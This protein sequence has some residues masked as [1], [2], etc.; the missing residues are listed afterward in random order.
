M[1]GRSRGPLVL[2][3][4]TFFRCRNPGLS[5]HQARRTSPIQGQFIRTFHDGVGIYLGVLRASSARLSLRLAHSQAGARHMSTSPVTTVAFVN[6]LS[7]NWQNSS[8]SFRTPSSSAIPGNLSFGHLDASS[9]PIRNTP[10]GSLTL[11]LHFRSCSAL[12]SII[13][14]VSSTKGSL[15]NPALITVDKGNYV[16]ISKRTWMTR[17]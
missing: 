16:V 14:T 17:A 15:L 11:A 6:S 8:P 13:S 7:W 1:L 2:N 9:S 12:H 4:I 5:T 10:P 3:T